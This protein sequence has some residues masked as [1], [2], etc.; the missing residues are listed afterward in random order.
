ML[1]SVPMEYDTV[2]DPWYCL[3]C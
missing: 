1:D 2:S 3:W